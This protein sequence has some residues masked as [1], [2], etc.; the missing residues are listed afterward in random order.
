[1]PSIIRSQR[2]SQLLEAGAAPMSNGES[3]TRYKCVPSVL[4]A[5]FFF[6]PFPFHRAQV[7]FLH[8]APSF[9]T[10]SSKPRQG[11]HRQYLR[12]RRGHPR[13]EHGACLPNTCYTN[14]FSKLP[15][16]PG[17]ELLTTVRA[18]PLLGHLSFKNR[19]KQRGR[20]LN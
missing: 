2:G 4:P 14:L 3:S 19:S 12:T 8:V 20:N 7:L 13:D 17:C 16:I 9:L 5:C 10:L 11:F 1:M 18:L 15:V 6:A